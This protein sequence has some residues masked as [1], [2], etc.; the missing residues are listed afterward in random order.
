MRSAAEVLAYLQGE[1]KV[2]VDGKKVKSFQ[3]E[4][5]ESDHF[6]VTGALKQDYEDIVKE[7]ADKAQPG[8]RNTDY[9]PQDIADAIKARSKKENAPR[10]KFVVYSTV[11]DKYE[12]PSVIQVSKCMWNSDTDT[13]CNITYSNSNF[14]CF[15][16]VYAVYTE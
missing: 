8:D 13:N 16:A 14:W 7:F 4:P 1:R 15:V 5:K 9:L 12:H 10:Y 3:I 6:V 2:T 11:L